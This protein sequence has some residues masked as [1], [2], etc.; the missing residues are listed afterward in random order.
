MIGS[1]PSKKKV[2]VLWVYP[3]IPLSTILPLGI[4]LLDSY[5]KGCKDLEVESEVF[6]T[7]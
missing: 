5:L 6:E 4:T 1:P 3:N 2:R 7:T